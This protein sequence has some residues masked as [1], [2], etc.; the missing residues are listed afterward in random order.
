MGVL[1]VNRL[2]ASGIQVAGL[3]ID[4]GGCVTVAGA[5]GSGKTLLLRAI[6]DLD[7]SQ[8]EVLLDGRSRDTMTGPE[9]RRRV[10]YVAAESAWWA[11]GVEEHALDWP[12]PALQRLG[13]E[14]DVLQ[15]EVQR[16]SSGE[17]QRLA[18]VRALAHQPDTLLLDEPTANLDHANTERVEQL[19]AEWRA[20]GGCTCWVSHDPAQRA[21]VGNVHFNVRDGVAEQESHG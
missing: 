4:R 13:F 1:S 8:G 21:R 20:T 6:A 14:P 7:P 17:R 10:T 15:W 11:P 16:L 19:I 9:W 12:L 3:V 2:Q 18:L 5:S